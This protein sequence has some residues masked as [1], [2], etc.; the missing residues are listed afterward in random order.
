MNENMHTVE[1]MNMVML[2][3][4]LKCNNHHQGHIMINTLQ[5]RNLYTSAGVQQNYDNAHHRAEQHMD[6]AARSV[7]SERSSPTK[8]YPSRPRT[9]N[10]N[11]LSAVLCL[12]KELDY[13]SLEV[14]EMAVRLASHERFFAT[15][16]NIRT[17]CDVVVWQYTR[18]LS[19]VRAVISSRGQRLNGPI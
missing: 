10:A 17:A 14:V 12:V 19:T 18:T 6:S 1:V 8:P 4:L 16:S 13:T 7:T 3:L 5:A 15:R 11:L 9:R 2:Q